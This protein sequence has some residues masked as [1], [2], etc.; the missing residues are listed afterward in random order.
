M[1]QQSIDEDDNYFGGLDDEGIVDLPLIGQWASEVYNY[2]QVINSNNPLLS[3]KGT[4]SAIERH[5]EEMWE[6]Y[7]AMQRV[8]EER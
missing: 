6:M 1:S 8:K 2:D 3:N 5:K 4:P 7:L